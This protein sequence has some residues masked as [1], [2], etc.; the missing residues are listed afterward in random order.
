MGNPAGLKHKKNILKAHFT[1]RICLFTLCFLVFAPP[2]TP[3]ALIPIY[4]PTQHWWKSA[5]STITTYRGAM[6]EPMRTSASRWRRRSGRPRQTQQR[7]KV[8]TGISIMTDVSQHIVSFTRRTQRS[9]TAQHF[10]RGV[11]TCSSLELR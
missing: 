4:P 5:I 7:L 8:S 11:S 9:H 1:S 2:P 3:G 10:S 6:R